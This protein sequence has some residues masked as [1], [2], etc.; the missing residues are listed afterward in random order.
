MLIYELKVII[1][2]D[3][4]NINEK[5][6]NYEYN[7]NN[8]REFVKSCISNIDTGKQNLKDFGYQIRVSELKKP[9]I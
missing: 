3:E 4:K 8:P 6:P 2:V 7:W 5:Y 9:S 1:K